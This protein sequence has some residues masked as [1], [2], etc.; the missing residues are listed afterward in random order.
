MIHKTAIIDPKAELGRDVTVGPFSYIE[1]D[2]TIGDN[3]T[4]GPHVTILRYTSLGAGCQVHA[5]ATLGDIPQDTGFANEVS[6]ARIGANCLIREGVTIHRGSKPGTTTEIG[7]NCFLMAFSHFAHNV[8]VGEG[9]IVANAVLLGGHVE[10]GPK[11][12]LSGNAA[13]HQFCKI[14]R[15]AMVGG[16]TGVSKD[17]PPFCSLRPNTLNGVTGINTVGMR[18]AGMTPQERSEVKQAFKIL[19]KSNLNVSQAEERI[20]A[21]FA[22]GPAL[23]FCTFIDQSTRG[24]C[25]TPE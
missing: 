3:S 12:F 23:E 4:I 14:G 25:T 17:V 19:Y 21:T 13:V 20:R 7:D 15:L 1:A 24:I 5:G 9:V 10:V 18:R 8:R 2:V 6:Y 11:T 16:L 22:S